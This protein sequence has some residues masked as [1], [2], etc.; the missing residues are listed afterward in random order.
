M[1]LYALHGIAILI[2]IQIQCGSSLG[3]FVSRGLRQMSPQVNWV[4]KYSPIAKLLL[5]SSNTILVRSWNALMMWFIG[6]NTY[7]KAV[8]GQSSQHTKF[9]IYVCTYT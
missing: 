6:R 7:Y 2:C 5:H 1:Q 3:H 8:L 4:K 9:N